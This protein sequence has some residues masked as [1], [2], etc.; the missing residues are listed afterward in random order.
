MGVGEVVSWELRAG[1]DGFARAFVDDGLAA[2][3]SP[4]ARHHR[5][6]P[7]IR[8]KRV[9]AEEHQA[10][11]H[12]TDA[13]R[14][15]RPV[16]AAPPYTAPATALQGSLDGIPV[17]DIVE[18]IVEDMWIGMSARGL[19]PEPRHPLDDD[20]QE[21]HDIPRRLRRWMAAVARWTLT[22]NVIAVAAIAQRLLQPLP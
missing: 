20:R 16:P 17:E 3:L 18:D 8:L 13:A 7:P 6:Q 2:A 11:A 4:R 19:G 15:Q 12:A 5:F 1:R 10:A 22:L 9:A 14:P 21:I